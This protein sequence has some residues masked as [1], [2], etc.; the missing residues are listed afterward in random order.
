MLDKFPDALLAVLLA[1]T[2]ALAVPPETADAREESEFIQSPRA[3][4]GVGRRRGES[5]YI[6]SIRAQAEQGDAVAQYNLGYA[7][8]NG[9][10]VPQDYSEAV[11]WYRRAAEQGNAGAQL[12]LGVMYSNGEGVPQNYRE[13]YIW[14]SLAAANGHKKAAEYRDDDARKLSPAELSSAQKEAAR[15]HAKIQGGTGN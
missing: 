12:N 8:H 2:F 4:V 7:Y 10:G 1:L 11:K 5:G 15:R 14:F 3:R 13:A 6:Q 9:E